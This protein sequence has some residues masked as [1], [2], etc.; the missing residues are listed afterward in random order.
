MDFKNLDRFHFL[1]YITFLIA[2]IL[3]FWDFNAW[4]LHNDELSTIFRA[5][6]DSLGELIEKG[7]R[8]DV[9]PILNELFIHFW[10]KVFGNSPF[11]VRIPYV[12]MSIAALFFFYEFFKRLSGRRV[13]LLSLISLSFTQLFV[14]YSQIARPYALGFFLISVFACCWIRM[15]ENF[16][17]KW[18]ILTSV[19]AALA[20][21]SHYFL[22]LAVL[23]LY[24]I[25]FF[26]FKWQKK[27]ILS[28]L[29]SGILALLLFSPH[30]E[31]SI[32]QIKQKG[33]GWLPTPNS[34]FFYDFI[35]FSLNKFLPL[36]LL[37]LMAPLIAYLGNQFRLPNRKE[38]MLSLVFILSFTIGYQ[39]SIQIEPV[40][41]KSTLIFS[42]PFIV[43]LPFQFFKSEG[44]HR[45]LW[46]YSIALFLMALSSLIF[47]A[48][49][50]GPKAFADFEMV[51]EKIQLWK[52]DHGSELT[53]L[54]SSSNPAYFDYYFKRKGELIQEDM[55]DFYGR[56]KIE[57]AVELIRDSK[58]SYLALAFANMPIPPEVYEYALLFYPEEIERK[59][60]FNSEALLLGKKL[61]N[62]LPGRKASFV[63]ELSDA[64]HSDR[65]E[66]RDELVS[67]SLY[68]SRPAA[69]KIN[70][71]DLYA[72]TF[73]AKVK[74]LFRD[75]SKWLT[76]KALARSE[77][78]SGVHL[79]VS[80]ER[81]GESIDWR[82]IELDYYHHDSQWFPV[83]FVY[84]LAKQARENDNLLIYFWNP[85][86]EEIWLDD[87]IVA[88]YMD[89]D[90]N[91]YQLR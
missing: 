55:D 21:M 2:A 7:V 66:I 76:L 20:A 46:I 43:A 57:Q 14:L 85:E 5:S 56:E 83:I 68:F 15:L 39:Y 45:L 90:F 29:G 41:Q 26:Y 37:I 73:R 87:I 9:H 91:Y 52:S 31:L 84:Q 33:L 17:R 53:V 42:F 19:I 11:A 44:K 32:S 71:D 1:L 78:N 34:D 40:I 13:A 70:S 23:L 65:W 60:G 62:E 49:V 58:S 35:Y 69:F 82:S 50:Y 28:Y 24:L 75:G 81:N 61:E 63:S 18:L 88:N 89:S 3:R 38:W 6:Y 48:R 79:A 86:A 12:I 77:I 25:G 72:L 54:S 22:A 80:I 30:L 67:D 16:D 36:I 10:M 4:S 47:S 59:R 51:A 64:Q 74:H 8:T 27:S